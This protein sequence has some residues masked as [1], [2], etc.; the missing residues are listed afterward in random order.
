[1]GAQDATGAIWM[2]DLSFSHRA[3]QPRRIISSHGG[4][5]NDIAINEQSELMASVGDLFVRLYKLQYGL[6]S[7]DTTEL[8]C[9]TQLLAKASTIL[10]RGRRHCLVGHDDGVVRLYAFMNQGSSKR[11]VVQQ[12]VKPHTK[13]VTR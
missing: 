11:L 8:I 1:M 2:L 12:A 9:E 5:V 3:K 13:E 4:V 10:W 7:S 6:L